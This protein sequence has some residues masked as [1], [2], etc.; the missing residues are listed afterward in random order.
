MISG[1]K[2]MT[3]GRGFARRITKENLDAFAPLLGRPGLQSQPGE[4]EEEWSCPFA[5]D[6]SGLE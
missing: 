4:N 3:E 5:V 1:L 2:Q 6:S